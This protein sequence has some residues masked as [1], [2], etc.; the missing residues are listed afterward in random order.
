LD[1]VKGEEGFDAIICMG[2]SFAHLPDFSGDQHDQR[3]AISNFHKLLKPGGV[4]V[5]DH[6]NYDFIL[7]NGYA[8]TN[9]IYYNVNTPILHLFVSILLKTYRHVYMYT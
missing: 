5:I 9:N 2:N 6:R 4:L 8:P 1:E 7:E 3:L